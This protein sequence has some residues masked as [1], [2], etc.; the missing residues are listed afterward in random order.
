M[1]ELHEQAGIQLRVLQDPWSSWYA[2]VASTLEFSGIR[3]KTQLPVNEV[4]LAAP[5][6]A[7]WRPPASGHGA[8]RLRG[9]LI[10]PRLGSVRTQ[11]GLIKPVPLS[12]R[13]G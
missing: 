2:V 13:C 9:A 1:L 4:R 3:L 7:G 12:T 6:D 5:T 8:P 10:G 11:C